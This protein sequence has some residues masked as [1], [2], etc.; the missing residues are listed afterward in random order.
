MYVESSSQA[1]NLKLMP[2]GLLKSS[3]RTLALLPRAG[4]SGGSVQCLNPSS[5]DSLEQM[6]GFALRPKQT[7]LNPCKALTKIVCRLI[8]IAILERFSVA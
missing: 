4:H 1:V 7:F 5:S 6:D 2:I 8:L 3:R